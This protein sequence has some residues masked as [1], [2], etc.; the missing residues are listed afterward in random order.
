PV[1]VLVE[2]TEA[3]PRYSGITLTNITVKESPQWLKDKLTAI[4]IRCIN[5][6]VDV[7]NFILHETGQPLHAFDLKEI[8]GNKII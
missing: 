6:V 2:N 1:E 7:T 5:N 3:C 8:K 4:G